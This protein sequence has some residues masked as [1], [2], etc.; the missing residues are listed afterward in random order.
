MTGGSATNRWNNISTCPFSH[1]SQNVIHPGC[2]VFSGTPFP[3][4]TIL[5]RCDVSRH[6]PAASHTRRRTS[7]PNKHHPHDPPL[8]F[9]CPPVPQTSGARIFGQP[10]IPQRQKPSVDIPRHS[11]RNSP[12]R[13]QSIDADGFPHESLFSYNSDK[14]TAITHILSV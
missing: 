13:C 1:R 2:G 7:P 10:A 9:L 14:L 12:K 11:K 4:V 3:V 8:R 5:P 6:T